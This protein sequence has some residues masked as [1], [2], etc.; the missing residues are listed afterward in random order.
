MSFVDYAREEL[1]RAGMFDADSDYNGEAGKAVMELVEVFAKQG[2]SGAS[3][4]LVRNLFE[5]VTSYEPLTPLSSDPDEWH[6]VSEGAGRPMWQSKRKP[7]VFSN[8]G[9]QTWYDIDEVDD[10]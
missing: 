7:T 10:A 1:T 8:D 9:G 3:A 4:W 2:H 5:K 6:D